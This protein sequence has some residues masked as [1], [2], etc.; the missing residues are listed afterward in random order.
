MLF[1]VFA[2]KKQPKLV[3][4]MQRNLKKCSLE[5]MTTLKNNFGKCTNFEV[6]SLGLGIFDEVSVANSALTFRNFVPRLE[7]LTLFRDFV[8][9][10]KV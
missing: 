2:G 1:V 10:G 9:I 6:S 8:G 4:K 7:L 3:G 5:V